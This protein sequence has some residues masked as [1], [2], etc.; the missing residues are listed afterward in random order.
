M[1]AWHALPVADVLERLDSHI[2]GLSPEEAARR[3][4]AHGPNALGGGRERSRLEI[5]A[6]QVA[7][8][9]ASL[10]LASAGVSSLL[11][12]YFDSGAILSVV[13]LNTAIGYRIERANEQLLASWQRLEAGEARVIRGN[14]VRA[15]PA[16]DLV[17]GDL[18][19]C[20]VGD[21]LP[22]DARIVDAHHLSSDES[23]L[24]G[25]SEPQTKSAEP[26]AAGAALADRSSMLYGGTTI[27]SG[28]A[29]AVVTA[30][31]TAT[32][33]AEI[34]RL[35]EGEQSPVTPLERRLA[36]LTNRF[37]VVGVAAGA[38]TTGI[39]L[40]R[41]R[42]LG[43]VL[44]SG[45]ALSVAA[46]PEGL[47]V[48]ATAAL[49]RAM[50]RMR[51]RGM[52]V[53]RLASAE[54][55]GGVSVI[56][57]D[58]TGTLTRN[59]MRLEII[60]V[61]G[62]R[63]KPAEI[64]AKSK[65]VFADPFA[66]ALAVSVL[67]SDVDVQ[68]GSDGRQIFGS[69][70]E[71]AL[72]AAAEGAGLERSELRRRFPR[73]VLR[74]R[75]EGVNYVVS[76][77]DHGEKGRL[78][79]IKGAPE[80]VLPLCSRSPSG[81]LSEAARRRLK[82]RNDELAEA[83]L[84]VLALGWRPLG[85][86]GGAL[87]RGYTFIGLAGLRDPLR[88]GAGEAVKAA[89]RAGIR[90]LILTGDQRRTAEAIARAVGLEGEAIDGAEALRRVERGG[91][92]ALDRVAVVSRIA[93]ADKVAIVKALRARGAIV[94]MAGDGVNDAPALKA[95]DV[96]IAVGIGSSDLARQAADV[97]LENEDLRSILS[98]VGEGRIIQDNLRRAVR[99]LLAT[100]TSEIALI[101]GATL[102][103]AR[104]PLGSL[105][106]L[107]L[108]LLSDTL[109][110]LALA[111]EPGNPDV[112]DRVPAPPEASLLSTEARRSVAVDGALMAGMGA[113]ALLLG[114]PP[115]A[116][117]TITGLQL[118]YPL[119]CRAPDNP[120]G[121]R[122]RN[123]LGGAVALQLAALTVPPLRVFL[124]LPRA[125]RGLELAAFAGGLLLPA[126]ASRWS[127][128]V[129]ERKGNGRLRAEERGRAVRDRER[130]SRAARRAPSRRLQLQGSLVERR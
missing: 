101:L 30:T 39:G 68:D 115:L 46:I 98:A 54:T 60:E 113:G 13:G 92:A 72:V 32:A 36:R 15:I 84:R 120:P 63:K 31:A 82:R 41:G 40:L 111:L 99:Y 2:G 26:V 12:D 17:P 16:T 116:F 22:A 67:N 126:A 80:Q 23:V 55:L 130:T 77:H 27:A 33:V 76:V 78:A 108:N 10:L 93:P 91:A 4:T 3:L 88:P 5:L 102:A 69:S 117:A 53:R 51:R 52:V 105:Q 95:A 123:L 124:G 121:E 19:L 34:K 48:V 24:T 11:R 49:V 47:P 66:L 59:E 43:R 79:F 119:L 89:A 14:R 128:Q 94:A 103:G 6:A 25:E 7:N 37:A 58:K 28:H 42:P 57:A 109:P 127:S 38:L 9:P 61:G 56:C 1:P 86:G 73:R 85:K 20:R 96:G 44:R 65:D 125:V 83:G 29:R 8:L 112:L 104:E 62:M 110:A 71:R 75:R 100:N 64:R 21:I 74:E 97:V 106:L 122:F 35:L 118:G 70:T 90:T 129:I 18:L 50:E 81:P 87:D 114:G 45:V 107:W